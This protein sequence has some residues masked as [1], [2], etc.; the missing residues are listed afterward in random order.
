VRGKTVDPSFVRPVLVL[1]VSDMKNAREWYARV[2]GFRTA[3]LHDDP[4][5]DPVG[6]YAILTHDQAKVHLILD[7]P[8]REHPWTTAGT[9][10][11]FL[12]V[13]SV[14]AVYAMEQGGLDDWPCRVYIGIGTRE[15]PDELLNRSAVPWS[16]R[17]PDVLEL[18]F[19][20]EH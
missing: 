16:R 20:P 2:L 10:Y 1:P 11:L 8:P 9:G 13:R 4:V 12:P 3:Y 14:E 15:T 17:L 7:K 18:L 6:Y 19:G 5:E